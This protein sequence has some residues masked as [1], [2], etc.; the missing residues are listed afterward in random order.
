MGLHL[1]ADDARKGDTVSNILRD[2]GKYVGVITRAEKLLSRNNVE[3]LGLSIK[4]DDG[5][6]ASYLDVYT[7]RLADGEHLRGYHLVQALLACLKLRD[8][9]EGA[10]EADKW[11]SDARMQVRTK[12][13]GYP[14]LMGKRIGVFLQREI[15]INQNTGAETD[16]LNLIG[17]F[18]PQT[19]LTATE[20]LGGKTEPKRIH[21]YEKMLERAPILDR[22]KGRG[23]A[24]AGT[25]SAPASNGAKPE[26]DDDIPFNRVAA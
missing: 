10:I 22:R 21:D 5:C 16:R 18:D 12:L 13:Q 9:E 20:I 19:N 23:G 17:V 11:D 1:N 26:F 8:V 7:V 3:G 2:S 6:T 15:A 24:N 25:S 4:T 14:A